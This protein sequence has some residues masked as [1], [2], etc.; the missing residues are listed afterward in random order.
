M[1]LAVFDCDGTL[2]DGQAPI[3]EAMEAAFAA[4]SLPAPSR[5]AIRRAV[6]L[7]LP[8][9]IR[10]LLP[11]SDA[12]RQDAMAEAYKLSFRT[13]REQGRVAQ[14]LFPGIADTLRALHGAGW[15]LGVATGMSD[16]G[17]A[18]CL[19]ANGI[20]GL[21]VTLQTA[22]R[23]PSKPHPAMLEQALAE[24]GALPSEAVMIGDTA[25]DIQ[26][27]TTAHVRA[28]G[29]DWGYHHPRELLAAGAEAVVESPAQL[30]EH[31][32]R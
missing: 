24:A 20:A 19:D 3:C 13:A 1:K 17:L 4:F 11:E 5:G 23:H 14:P 27:A 12:A 28:I 30:A 26:M 18:F 2:V 22:D 32:L 6:G 10:Q 31:L 15:T 21:F 29:V 16:R 9:A 7:S 8:Q 25:Y